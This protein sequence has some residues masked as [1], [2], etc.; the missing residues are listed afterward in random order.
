MNNILKGIITNPDLLY[1]RNTPNGLLDKLSGHIERFN[2]IQVVGER[3]FGKTSVLKCIE[4]RLK[5]EKKFIPVFIDLKEYSFIK[6]NANVY[7][8]ILSRCVQELSLCGFLDDEIT[9]KGIL[10]KKYIN[11]EDFFEQI[12]QIADYRMNDIL[13]EFYSFFSEYYNKTFTLLIDEYEHLFLYSFDDPKGFFLFRNIGQAQIEGNIAA[14]SFVIAG[15]MTWDKLCT[16][17]GSAELNTLSTEIIYVDPLKIESFKKW[18]EEKLIPNFPQDITTDQN[19]YDLSGGVPFYAMLIVESINSNKPVSFNMLY[20]HFE[21]VYRNLDQ[22]ETILLK[23]IVK[24]ESFDTNNFLTQLLINKGL[25]RSDLKKVY[26]KSSLFEEYLSSKIN[27]KS[28]SQDE[29]QSLLYEIVSSISR[30]MSSINETCENK[31]KKLIFKPVN[32]DPF[33]QNDL[34]IKCIDSDDIKRFA[35]SVYLT[36]FEKTKDNNKSLI[37][38][39]KNFRLPHDFVKTIDSLRHFFGGHLKDTF[40]IKPGQLSKADLLKKIL[41]SPNNPVETDYVLIQKFVL[42]SFIKYLNDIEKYVKDK[43]NDN[44]W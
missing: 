6:G 16:I 30:K 25:I 17:T 42:T 44:N 32:Q 21:E 15:T 26:I 37:L 39:P 27:L 14:L 31:N 36:V 35:S 19:L 43:K 4:T 9:L 11:W 10:F 24:K 22:K 12:I 40:S 23:K 41:N 18:Y 33:L 28:Y 2:N 1:G 20:P 29:E 38:L 3:R 34:Q 8:F 5:N 7:R 13:K